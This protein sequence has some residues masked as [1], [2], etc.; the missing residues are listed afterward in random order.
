M[1]QWKIPQN[2]NANEIDE[3]DMPTEPNPQEPVSPFTPTTPGG[4]GLF[5]GRVVPVPQPLEQ[6]FPR[7]YVPTP[8]S[9]SMPPYSPG[10]A[11]YSVPPVPPAQ[12]QQRKGS[13]KTGGTTGAEAN[14]PP[15]PKK[16]Q[17]VRIVQSR[18]SSV[19]ALVKLFFIAVRL[20]LVAQF[21][22]TL[23]NRPD[24]TPWIS[25]VY[26]LSPIFIWPVTMLIGQLHLP[27]TLWP[28]FYTLLAI[29]FYS[30]LSRI[31]VGFL[32][33]FMY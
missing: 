10:A 17:P 32:K 30:V 14:Q 12:Q 2:K 27:F 18:H 1:M 16:E 19:P 15:P 20:L 8:P 6:P 21:V 25:I 13:K 4:D 5:Y 29:V 33:V 31:L 3:H 23:L 9:P 24:T 7:K 28:G 26:T 11:G 22:L